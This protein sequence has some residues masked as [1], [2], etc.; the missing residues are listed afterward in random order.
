M[1]PSRFN[2]GNNQIWLNIIL[3][4]MNSRLS[5]KKTTFPRIHLE[6][7]A[8]TARCC[9]CSTYRLQRGT[10]R[11]WRRQESRA[12]VGG[13]S[14]SSSIPMR[15][16]TTDTA[17]RWE[18]LIVSFIP[19]PQTTRALGPSVST[20]PPARLG[21]GFKWSNVCVCESRAGRVVVLS[22]NRWQHVSSW[23]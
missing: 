10:S 6:H 7:C 12:R 21:C 17:D 18:P 20:S 1:F 14:S 5:L 13:S 3:N 11:R 16:R 23:Q 2:K 8:K 9:A 19:T 4:S 15:G 22:P